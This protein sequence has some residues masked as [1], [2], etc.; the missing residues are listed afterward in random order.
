MFVEK[1]KDIESSFVE[2]SHDMI[3]SEN[4]QIEAQS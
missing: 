2:L 1:L 4:V 3:E